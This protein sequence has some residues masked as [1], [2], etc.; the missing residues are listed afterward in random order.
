ML[1]LM[2]DQMLYRILDQMLGWKSDQITSVVGS[3]VSSTD[4]VQMTHHRV[5]SDVGSYVLSDVGSYVLSDV[6]SDV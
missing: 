2:P 3:D 1:D 4:S 6:G 5:G